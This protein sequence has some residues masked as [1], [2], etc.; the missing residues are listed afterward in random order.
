MHSG[1]LVVAVGVAIA[2]AVASVWYVILA[3]KLVSDIEMA[4]EH[5]DKIS[6]DNEKAFT[7]GKLART[8]FGFILVLFALTFFAVFGMQ[9]WFMQVLTTGA[10]AF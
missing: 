4:G 9:G 2:S 8:A 10:I 3:F 6:R 1:Q 5:P 7:T